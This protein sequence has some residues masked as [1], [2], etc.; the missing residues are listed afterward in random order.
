MYSYAIFP[1]LV[2][3]FFWTVGDAGPYNAREHTSSVFRTYRQKNHT[4]VVVSCAF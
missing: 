4:I 1:Y 2:N 3:S